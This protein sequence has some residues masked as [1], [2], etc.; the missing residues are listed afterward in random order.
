MVDGVQVQDASRR[1]STSGISREPRVRTHATRAFSQSL[2]WQAMLP[3]SALMSL[4]CYFRCCFHFSPPRCV[5][6]IS[7]PITYEITLL[8]AS[9]SSP[10]PAT[11]IL[12]RRKRRILC[13]MPA[14]AITVIQNG[15]CCV[16]IRRMAELP[17]YCAADPNQISQV[18]KT[19]EHP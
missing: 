7:L 6:F 8:L 5:T 15:T 4:I 19:R 17:E 12:S 9:K 18:G 13:N 10:R 11:D 3:A 2:L 14:P 16:F 1:F